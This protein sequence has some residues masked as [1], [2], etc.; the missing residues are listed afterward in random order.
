[1]S[2]PTGKVEHLSRKSAEAHADSIFKKDGHLPN[3]FVCPDCGYL[4]VGG[5]RASDRPVIRP[6][7]IRTPWRERMPDK[8]APGKTLTIEDLILNELINTYKTDVAIANQFGV[9]EFIVNKVRKVLDIPQAHKRQEETIVKILTENPS[10]SR[11]KLRELVGASESFVINVVNRNG[12]AGK[13]TKGLKGSENPMF[14]KTHKPE[15]KAAM[16][17]AHRKRFAEHPEA[18]EIVKANLQKA[19]TPEA[20]QRKKVTMN[21]PYVR[22][23]NSRRGKK[24]WEDPQKRSEM[25]AAIIEATNTP[26]YRENRS[27]ISKQRQAE[28][29]EWGQA[30]AARAAEYRK[31]PV[32]MARQKA[33]VRKANRKRV[34]MG[35]TNKGLDHSEES[36]LNMTVAQARFGAKRQGRISVICIR[37]RKVSQ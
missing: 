6:A 9:E 2:C 7:Q 27:K 4:H 29:P 32:W 19:L 25:T 28:H 23:A 24:L 3:I 14:M 11:K 13:G 35:R 22:A 21:L 8:A 17:A 5:G 33:A 36:R 37:Y 12:F 26:E 30:F 1:M 10:I 31:D 16:G 15:A 20:K 34:E 18:K